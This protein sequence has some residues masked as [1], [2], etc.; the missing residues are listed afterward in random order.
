MLQGLIAGTGERTRR[1]DSICF[2]DGWVALLPGLVMGCG[3]SDASGATTGRPPTPEEIPA[4]VAI[5]AQKVIG[6]FALG[7]LRHAQDVASFRVTGLITV[8]EYAS[9]V[10]AGACAEPNR[11]TLA[12]DAEETEAWFA[13][14]WRVRDRGPDLP[15]VCVSPDNA[16]RFCEWI[17]GGL[18]SGEQWLLA[19]RGAGTAAI[20]RFAW[21]D[22]LP[23]CELHPGTFGFSATSCCD[24][25]CA[26]FERLSVG[27]YPKG[28]SVNGVTDVLLTPAELIGPSPTA[29]FPVCRAEPGCLVTGSLPGAIDG[30]LPAHATVDSEGPMYNE[31]PFGFR[32]VWKEGA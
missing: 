20:S 5:G 19:A 11:T 3:K 25:D 31:P 16:R 12:C 22:D 13:N 23:T 1:C 30:F 4:S 15:A 29:Q 14:T 21:G 28:A 17:G 24:E 32:C 8:S 18:P 26:P 10:S 2:G 7:Q 9:C 27:R 6:G